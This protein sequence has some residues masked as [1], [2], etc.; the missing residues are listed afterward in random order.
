VENGPELIPDDSLSERAL[1]L[2][3]ELGLQQCYDSHYL[4][5]A[6]REG[7]E[8]WTADKKCWDAVQA[9]LPWA[10]W[11]GNYHPAAAT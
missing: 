9:K 1:S 2:S 3:G 8:F 10:K 5:L 11:L 7:A 6:E 4:A